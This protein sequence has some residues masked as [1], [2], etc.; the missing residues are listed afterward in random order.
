MFHADVVGYSCALVIGVYSNDCDDW[1][2]TVN[3]V[4]SFTDAAWTLTN[5]SPYFMDPS[6][7]KNFSQ[8]VVNTPS[9]MALVNIITI[10]YGPPSFLR[11]M[12]ISR[13]SILYSVEKEK[14]RRLK[15]DSFTLGTEN[16]YRS[17]K[18]W[19]SKKNSTWLRR[20]IKSFF[21]AWAREAFVAAS[22]PS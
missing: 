13:D 18:L 7:R 22:H 4:I 1:Q 20:Q 9:Y 10:L 19:N 8:F 5:L 17:Y 11:C 3:I 6:S 2:E 21:H 16:L 12:K 14:V 15:N